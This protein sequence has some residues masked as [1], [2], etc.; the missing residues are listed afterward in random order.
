[1]PKLVYCTTSDIAEAE[2]I[3]K[4]LLEEK[5]VACVNIIPSIRSMYRWKGAIEIGTESAL[6]IKT[7]DGKVAETIDRVKELHSYDV[8]EIIALDLVDGSKE[9]FDFLRK[10]TL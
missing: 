3:A 7:V 4:T 2:K 10:E 9:Y 6:F 5:L 8:A 1:M